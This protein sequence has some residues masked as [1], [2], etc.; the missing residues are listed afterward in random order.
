MDV[1]VAESGKACHLKNQ[2]PF[3]LMNFSKSIGTVFCV[4]RH[5]LIETQTGKSNFDL[6]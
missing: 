2:G 6:E 4:L 1:K 3:H 5:I